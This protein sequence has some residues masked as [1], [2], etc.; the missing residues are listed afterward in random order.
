MRFDIMNKKTGG[1]KMK[2]AEA[3]LIKGNLQNKL[4]D[5]R[6]RLENNALVALDENPAED[7]IELMKETKSTINELKKYT[8][9][10][11]LTNASVIWEGRT[12]TELLAEREYMKNELSIFRNFLDEASR[13][14]SR[15]RGTEIKI[16]STVSV[17]EL[18]KNLDN[19]ASELR[20]LEIK[21]QELNW[22]T[23][24][25]EK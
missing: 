24:L 11:N 6:N 3:L 1:M 17:K 21:I 13:T 15:T 9:L 10:I 20:K 25:L 14:G 19:M 7:P 23:E 18:Q 16:V 22:T 5:L 2:L 4:N 8:I 12:I